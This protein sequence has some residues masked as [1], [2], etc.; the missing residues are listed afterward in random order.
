MTDTDAEIEALKAK[1]SAPRAQKRRE[2]MRE[3]QQRPEVKL[4]IKP[5]KAGLSKEVI[6][7]EVAR[8]LAARAAE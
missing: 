8:F 3:Y 2:Y 4:R 6:A 1:L 7:A 5:R